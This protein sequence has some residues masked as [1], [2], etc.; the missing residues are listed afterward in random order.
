MKNETVVVT[1]SSAGLGRAV[2]H[3]FGR[4]GA[5]VALLARG[6]DGLEG[7][8]REIEAAG[9][10]ALVLPTDVADSGEGRGRCGSSRERVRPNRHL[11]Q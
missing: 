5:N 6:V 10:K 8:K 1:G 3:E 9:G 7:A 4:R 2:A 11:D